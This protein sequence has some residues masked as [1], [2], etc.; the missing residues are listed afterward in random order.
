MPG[1]WETG[2]P[3]PVALPVLGKVP[4]LNSLFVATPKESQRVIVCVT[5]RPMH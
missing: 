4:L 1:W 3:E 2:D 5:A